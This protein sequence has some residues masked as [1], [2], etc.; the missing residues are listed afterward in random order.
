MSVL[1][2]LIVVCEVLFWVVLLAGLAARYVL[3]RQRLSSVL[4]VCAPLVDLVLLVASV[5]D[6]R[7]G[8]T[9]GT[10]HYLAAIYIGVS[11]G[12]GH[13]MVA[14]ADERF[15][16]RFAGGPRPQGKPR[17]GAAHAAYERGMWV[18][19]LVAWAVGCGLM[20]TAVL[21][22]GDPQRT[23]ALA[24]AMGLWTLALIIDGVIAFS[25]SLSPKKPKAQ[26]SR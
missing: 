18:R 7:G 12:F 20:G 9:A 23:A 13:T 4:L 16:H 10:P 5:L 25:Y 6:L 17:H 21:L 8:G 22:I 15:A 11:V 3:H 19:H 1:I 14:L 24:G 2:G 26:A